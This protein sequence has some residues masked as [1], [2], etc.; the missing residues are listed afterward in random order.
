[1]W[2]APINVRA[3]SCLG[4]SAAVMKVPSPCQFSRGRK[5]SYHN[6]GI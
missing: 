2:E 5:L 4:P 3:F 1:M 6:R